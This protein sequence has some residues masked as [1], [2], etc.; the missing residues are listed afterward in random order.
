MKVKL[1]IPSTLNTEK[2]LATTTIRAD[3]KW[4]GFL[5]DKICHKVIH[6][7][8]RKHYIF[9]KI[10]KNCMYVLKFKIQVLQILQVLNVRT[11]CVN[12]TK[13]VVIFWVNW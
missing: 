6:K 11:I 4:T 3:R 2:E 10:Y 13:S 7:S 12:L 9:T 1:Y 8:F 5:A